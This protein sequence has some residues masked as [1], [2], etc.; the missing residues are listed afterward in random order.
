VT[1]EASD[2]S[3]PKGSD[4]VFTVSANANCRDTTV[5]YSMRGKAK[6]GIDYTL[7]G[8]PGQV[9]IPAGRTTATITLHALN[10]SRKKAAPAKMILQPGSG[11]SLGKP[12]KE[13]VSLLP[14]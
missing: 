10:N 6:L 13:N 9:T 12:S 8:T 3:V 7:S 4:T 14:H 2:H 5:F 1:L 11:Y